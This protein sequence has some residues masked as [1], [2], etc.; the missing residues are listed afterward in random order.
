MVKRGPKWM[1]ALENVMAVILVICLVLGVTFPRYRG[2]LMPFAGMLALVTGLFF[3]RSYA[4][5]K[6]SGIAIK[7]KNIVDGEYRIEDILTGHNLGLRTVIL[8]PKNLRLFY[9][10]ADRMKHF[11]DEA[12]G[13]TIEIKNG[14]IFSY[15]Y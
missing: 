6:Y 15:V 2:L 12:I 10:I 13:A 7:L 1:N 8:I 5:Q 14:K 3:G 4:I 11:P 9:H